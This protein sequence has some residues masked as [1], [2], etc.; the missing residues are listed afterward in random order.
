MKSK[1]DL[2]LYQICIYVKQCL[3]PSYKAQLLADNIYKE[4][5]VNFIGLITLA[6]ENSCKYVF[7]IMDSYLKYC[8]LKNLHKKREAGSAFKKFVTFIKNQTN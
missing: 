4:F 7:T 5:H 2:P 6:S 1:E 8:W 3:N